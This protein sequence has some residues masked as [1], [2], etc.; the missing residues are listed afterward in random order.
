LLGCTYNW[1]CQVGPCTSDFMASIIAGT[2][3]PGSVAGPFRRV[4]SHENERVDIQTGHGRLH[5][6]HAS[7]RRTSVPASNGDYMAMTTL[8]MTWRWG[9][10]HG[11]GL[12]RVIKRQ[13]GLLANSP[14]QGNQGLIHRVGPGFQEGSA[15]N[16]KR[17][18]RC[19]RSRC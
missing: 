19:E 9:L 7:L 16:G 5:C 13:A 15:C 11:S 2:S 3:R 8:K 10:L 18:S 1:S 17:Y 12:I 6:H 4:R 14:G